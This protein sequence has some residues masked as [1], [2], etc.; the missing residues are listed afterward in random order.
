MYILT[1]II[2]LFNQEKHVALSLDSIFMQNTK[3]KYKIVVC[4]DNSSDNGLEIVKSYQ[5]THKNIEILESKVNQKLYK[6]ILRAYIA[7][8]TKYF[9]VLDPDDFWIDSNMIEEAIDFLESNPSFSTFA[10]NTN[11]RTNINGVEN[12][13]AYISCNEPK[14]YDFNNFLESGAIMG[15]TSAT[16]FRN[17]IFGKNMPKQMLELKTSSSEVSF[18]G[19]SFRNMV[20]L[21]EGKMQ[22]VPR[23]VSVYRVH[24]KGIWQ[25]LDKVSQLVTGVDFYID[26]WEFYDRKYDTFLVRAFNTYKGIFELESFGI[27]MFNALLDSRFYNKM[28]NILQKMQSYHILFEANL[29]D[30]DTSPQHIKLKYR[31]YKDIYTKLESKLKRKQLVTNKI[32]LM[33]SFNESMNVLNQVSQMGG[34][35]GR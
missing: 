25:S 34:G 10:F 22:Y 30:F 33:Q 11:V 4:D 2:P 31:I 29:K 1:I 32:D 9:C 3:Y 17:A 7:L 8:D 12:D 6:N 23:I 16:F 5:K 21:H 19:D 20:H 14:S 24:D 13:V 35:G 27:M 26:M 18:R 28:Q 15:H